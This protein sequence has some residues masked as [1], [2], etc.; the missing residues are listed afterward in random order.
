MI[1]Q[2]CLT[3]ITRG[4]PRKIYKKVWTPCFETKTRKYK[5]DKVHTLAETLLAPILA[6]VTKIKAISPHLAT[7][8]EL[9]LSAET[10]VVQ[11]SVVSIR[12]I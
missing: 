9:M 6:E 7:F 3:I 12:E 4:D 10:G 2:W 1:S 11:F 5:E 8:L